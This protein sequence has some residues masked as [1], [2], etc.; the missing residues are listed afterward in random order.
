MSSSR[1]DGAKLINR[2]R[3][4]LSITCVSHMGKGRRARY[5]ARLAFNEKI[6]KINLIVYSPRQ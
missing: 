6:Q 2:V 1:Q 3:D 5:N 4:V